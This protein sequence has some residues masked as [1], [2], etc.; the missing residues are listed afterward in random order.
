MIG[1]AGAR[2]ARR[3]RSWGTAVAG[4]DLPPSVCA[5]PCVNHHSV[6]V[7]GAFVVNA[8]PGTNQSHNT[9]IAI[10]SRADIAHGVL[11]DFGVV[12]KIQ[13]VRPL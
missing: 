11:L 13:P 8:G 10:R 1:R 7:E 9:N 4:D 12:E 2:R 5:A 6:Y 3:G